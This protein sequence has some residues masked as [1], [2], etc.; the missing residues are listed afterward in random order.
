MERGDG[1]R[2]GQISIGMS[3]TRALASA[4]NTVRAGYICSLMPER[5][6]HQFT[7]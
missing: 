6:S 7:G 3:A 5:I 1:V 4:V 2:A